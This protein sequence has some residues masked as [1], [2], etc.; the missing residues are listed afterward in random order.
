MRIRHAHFGSSAIAAN[1][2]EMGWEVMDL[3][4]TCAVV[5]MGVCFLL[6]VSSFSFLQQFIPQQCSIQARSFTNYRFHMHQKGSK[7]RIC[8]LILV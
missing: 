3:L 2:Q 4:D 7:V 8:T 5:H 1:D 6:L